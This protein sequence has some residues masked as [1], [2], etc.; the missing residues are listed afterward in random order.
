[1][2]LQGQVAVVTGSGQGIGKAIATRFAAEGA[3]IG[4]IDVNA[5]TAKATAGEIRDRGRRAL[6]IVA[7]VGNVKAVEVAVSEIVGELGRLDVLVNNAG[8]EK[9]APFLEI[10]PGDWERQ[11]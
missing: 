5:D 7:D 9:R 2:A 6:A 11:L 3:D 4:I 10:T 1:M 8:V